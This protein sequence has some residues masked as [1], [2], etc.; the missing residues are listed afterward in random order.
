MI[1]VGPIQTKAITTE[2]M[3]IMSDDD[4]DDWCN[5]DTIKDTISPARW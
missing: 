2:A 4:D 1:V 5:G 3:M